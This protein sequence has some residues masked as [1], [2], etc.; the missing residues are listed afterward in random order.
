MAKPK[1]D[2]E[3]L[4]IFATY[5]GVDAHTNFVAEVADSALD[6]IRGYEHEVGRLRGDLTEARAREL[7][8]LKALLME[9]HGWSWATVAY[10]GLDEARLMTR[11]QAPLD[12]GQ[13]QAVTEGAVGTDPEQL[14]EDLRT[15]T[16]LDGVTIDV[17]FTPEVHSTPIFSNRTGK[18]IEYQSVNVNTG[19]EWYHAA[20]RVREWLS[21]TGPHVPEEV[22]KKW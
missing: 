17:S 10:L 1:Y 18:L 7:G 12:P 9:R 20:T 11:T 16:S 5:D 6:V 8:A 13:I 22:E 21:P 14:L 2:L 4:T 3:D 19:I 15:L